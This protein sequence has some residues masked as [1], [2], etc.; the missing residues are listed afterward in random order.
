MLSAARGE[1][2]RAR[3]AMRAMWHVARA[4]GARATAHGAAP[5]SGQRKEREIIIAT[6]RRKFFLK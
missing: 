2:A 6:G 4:D 3:H 1:Q 5:Q